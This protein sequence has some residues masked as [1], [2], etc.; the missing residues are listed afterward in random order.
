MQRMEGNIASTLRER[1][2]RIG[3]IQVAD[4]PGRNQPGTGELN[5]PYLLATID[6]LGYD[7]YIGL[8]YTPK[9]RSEESFA[10]LPAGRRGPLPV[11]A[12]RL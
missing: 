2:D 5:F 11:E 1:I 6:E 3:H 7:G 12:L 9:G 4:S 8:E 10:W